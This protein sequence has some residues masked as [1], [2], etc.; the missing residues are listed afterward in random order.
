VS[1]A[2]VLSILC[3]AATQ[4]TVLRVRAVGADAER[5]VAELGIL[6][7]SNEEDLSG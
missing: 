6:I 5:A 3:L 1:G 4:G 7:E 2:S